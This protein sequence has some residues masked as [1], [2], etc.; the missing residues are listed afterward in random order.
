V[1]AATS[2]HRVS[3]VAVS[4]R[5]PSAVRRHAKSPRWLSS[6]RLSPILNWM[7]PARVV[8]TVVAILLLGAIYADLVSS[9]CDLLHATVSRVVVTGAASRG[10][11]ADPCGLGCVP[12]C[13]CC[14]QSEGAA[15][16]LVEHGS[17]I[18]VTA[19]EAPA[20]RASDGFRTLP[21]HPP[22]GLL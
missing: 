22:L 3:I 20:T 6:A 8:H 16:T 11:D 18:V 19:F 14:S 21:Y 12:D 9:H 5:G 15:F 1:P 10:T 17:C 13:Y 4:G 7:R 2:G